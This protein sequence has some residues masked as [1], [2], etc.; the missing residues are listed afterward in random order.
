MR[1]LGTV[2]IFICTLTFI[3]IG[4]FLI[5][6]A[7]NVLTVQNIIWLLE[8]MFHIKNMQLITGGIGFF[9][10]FASIFIAQITLGK[11][12]REKTIAFNNP[13][14]Q[15]TVSLSAIEEFI[16]RLSSVLPEVKDLRSNVIAGK[17]GID[18]DSRVS[19]W[20]DANI[21][22]TTESIQAVIK[23]RLQE[24]LGIE[25]AI[26]VRVHVGKIIPKEKKHSRKKDEDLETVQIAPYRDI[27]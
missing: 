9:L 19:L 2:L 14:G 27:I 5:A 24:M 8:V 22:Q 11:I 25:E 3:I 4:G 16:R 13:D 18:I 26:V 10:I 20:S 6:F 17:K 21:P 15:V 12:Q 7:L 1:I 23:S